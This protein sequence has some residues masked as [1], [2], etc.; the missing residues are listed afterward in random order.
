M[1]QRELE[2]DAPG[3]RQLT[4]LRPA[5]GRAAQGDQVVGAVDV[6]R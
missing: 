4:H 6:G 2:T 1:R 5:E 3:R